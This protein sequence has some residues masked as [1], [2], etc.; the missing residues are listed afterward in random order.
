MYTF[1]RH[2]SSNVTP[3]CKFSG[4]HGPCCSSDR[5]LLH[6]VSAKGYSLHLQ[7][8]SMQCLVFCLV[9]NYSSVRRRAKEIDSFARLLYPGILQLLK[10]VIHP[11]ERI[12][13]Y[14]TLR[15]TCFLDLIHRFVFKQGHGVKGLD[16]FSTDQRSGKGEVPDQPRAEFLTYVPLALRMR[17]TVMYAVQQIDFRNVFCGSWLRQMEPFGRTK[18]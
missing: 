8:P 1:T 3:L 10:V 13:W 17:S 6:H 14:I 18:Q 4:P 9:L 15:I 16:L 5:R 2:W 11:F 12:L 7:Y